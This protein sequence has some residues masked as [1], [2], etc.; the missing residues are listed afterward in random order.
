MAAE[1]FDTIHCWMPVLSRRRLY[2]LLLNPLSLQEPENALLLLSMTL[3]T[4]IPDRP[5]NGSRLYHLTKEFYLAA[6]STGCVTLQM[7]QA[8]ILIAL[9]E[10]GHGIYPA[11]FLTIATSCRFG[12]MLGL[13]KLSAGDVTNTDR[14]ENIR[15]WWAVLI[16]D[17]A[18][19]LGTEGS[20][21]C[22]PGPAPHDLLPMDDDD[23]DRS[24]TGSRELHR[25][26][27]PTELKAG[28]FARLVQATDL[29]GQGFRY[30]ASLKTD[31][32]PD[33]DGLGQL[34]RT[35]AALSNLA[36]AESLQR[37]IVFCCPIAWYPYDQYFTC[38]QLV[39]Y[40]SFH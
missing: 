7:V 27:M 12:T 11:A 5:G 20:H 34:T 39:V 4:S 10:L 36:H 15:V 24:T 30:L 29:L 17:H 33:F 32:Q 13:D 8:G 31:T 9:Y 16:V 23:W 3:I 1:Y 38:R 2:G 28:R 22:A 37:R 26:S 35:I 25:L 6:Q 21:L 40:E 14:E 18:L 19:N